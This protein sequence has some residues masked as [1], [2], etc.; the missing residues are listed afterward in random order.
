[1]KIIIELDTDQ[2]ADRRALSAMNAALIEPASTSFPE[3]K[4]R[5]PEPKPAPVEKP[6]AEPKPAPVEKPKAK[7]KS[8]EETANDRDKAI[9]IATEMVSS[10]R[11]AD[12][13][14]A[15]AAAGARRVSE[16]KGAQV[17][18]FLE[19]LEDAAE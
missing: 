3:P 16:L 10:G 2:A 12:V 5:A 7:P 13:K 9:A 18:K 19:A 14:V 6:K 1:M 11:T 15:L 8:A 4:N 17:A